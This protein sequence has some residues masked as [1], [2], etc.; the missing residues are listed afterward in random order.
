MTYSCEWLFNFSQS[1]VQSH[2]FVYTHYFVTLC[3]IHLGRSMIF[4]SYTGGMRLHLMIC[5]K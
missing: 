1:T 5:E 4:L 2:V 3:C